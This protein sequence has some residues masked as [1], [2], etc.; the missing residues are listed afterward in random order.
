MRLCGFFILSL[1]L[2]VVPALASSSRAWKRVDDTQNCDTYSVQSRD[3]CFSIMKQANVTFAQLISWNPEIDKRCFNIYNFVG[4]EICISNPEGDYTIPSNS[5]DSPT[6]VTTTAPVPDPTPD[7][8][9]DRCAEYHLVASGEDCGTFTLKYGITLKD[10]I[11]LNPHVWENCTNVYLDY[12][13]CVRPVG[14]ISTYPGYLP[15]TSTKEFVQTP[16]T[17]LPVEVDLLEGYVSTNQ[18]I[19]VADKTRDDCVA[20]IYLTDSSPTVLSDCWSMAMACGQQEFILWNPSLAQKPL[21]TSD[22]S[23]NYPCTLSQSVSYCIAL[24]SATAVPEVDEVAPPSPRA[25][26]EIENCTSWYAPN[27]YDTC[28]SML[29]IHWLEFDDFYRMNPSVKSDCTGMTLG[30]YYCV[31][32]NEDGSSPSEDEY[33]VTLTSSAS[34]TVTTTGVATP[35]PV[36]SGLS[37][38][39]DSFYLVKAGDGCWAIA[40]DHSVALSDFYDWN[41]AVKS[42]CT[43]LEAEVFVCVG[44]KTSATITVDDKTMS[45]TLGESGSTPTPVQDGMVSGCKDF[46]FVQSGDGCWAIANANGIELSDF[47]EWNPAVGDDCAGLQANVYVCTGK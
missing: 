8:T 18:K 33:D 28:E 37:S 36:Q 11:F 26:G 45:T 23:Y 38:N 15:T 43:G 5:Q 24:E 27:S 29:L 20:Y 3:D 14:Y 16:T 41:P 13:Y 1:S 44:V 35:S 39:C 19:L 30:T 31:S 6:I 40:N 22:H 46:Y 21:N 12:Y 9:E 32:T 17:P 4:K 7:D 47:Y 10:F 2:A 42:D 34:S 25:A